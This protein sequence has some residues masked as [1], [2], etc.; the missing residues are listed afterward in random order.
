M[1]RPAIN[2]VDDLIASLFQIDMNNP[3]SSIKNNVHD[4]VEKIFTPKPPAVVIDIDGIYEELR[5]SVLNA[6]RCAMQKHRRIYKNKSN[7]P[8]SVENPKEDLLWKENSTNCIF[9]I[10][11]ERFIKCNIHQWGDSLLP[12]VICFQLL[13]D[14][15]FQTHSHIFPTYINHYLLHRFHKDDISNLNTKTKKFISDGLKAPLQI[16]ELAAIQNSKSLHDLMYDKESPL[17]FNECCQLIQNTFFEFCELGKTLEYGHNDLHLGNILIENV[18]N[19]KKTYIIDL[20]R[21]HLPGIQLKSDSDG[22]TFGNITLTN[23]FSK[24]EMSP[25]LAHMSNEFQIKSQ[26]AYCLDVAGVVLRLYKAYLFEVK[27]PWLTIVPDHS[28]INSTLQLNLS[29]LLEFNNKENLLNTDISTYGLI[30]FVVYIYSYINRK[31]KHDYNFKTL[32]VEPIDI[33]IKD[34]ITSRLC[35]ENFSFNP[36]IYDKIRS[37]EGTWNFEILMEMVLRFVSLSAIFKEYTAS[38]V[39]I[40]GNQKPLNVDEKEDLKTSNMKYIVR[41]MVKTKIEGGND[42]SDIDKEVKKVQQMKKLLI[43]SWKAKVASNYP[44]PSNIPSPLVKAFGGNKSVK[45]AVKTHKVYTSDGRKYIRI[46][47]TRWFLDDNRGKYKWAIKDDKIIMR[48][49]GPARRIK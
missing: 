35:F 44:K 1:E 32:F 40:G 24:Y 29:A 31:T 19:V 14:P 20:G 6:R 43:N 22:V 18:N 37:L 15:Q 7:T 5:Q 12:E 28:F 41:D 49:S 38:N 10:K 27:Y 47:N 48:G 23:V 11:N 34:L 8:V 42:N 33:P 16:I 3:N 13:A 21:M 2:D 36:L 9:A 45:T 25:N 39:L 30:V 17:S 46:N 4:K 26:Y